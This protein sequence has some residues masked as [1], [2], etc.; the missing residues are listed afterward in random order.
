ME[1]CWLVLEDRVGQKTKREL[2]ASTERGRVQIQGGKDN[3]GAKQ[4]EG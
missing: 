1:Q 4:L 2:V 3:S